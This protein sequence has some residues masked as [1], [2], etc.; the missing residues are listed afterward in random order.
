[1]VVSDHQQNE[2]QR[3]SE[4]F[5]LIPSHAEQIGFTKMEE[6][7]IR[8]EEAVAILRT[9]MPSVTLQTNYYLT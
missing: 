2:L 4:S 6:R 8:R 7:M 3:S 1:M 5:P 9:E